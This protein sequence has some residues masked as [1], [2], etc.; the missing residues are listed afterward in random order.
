MKKATLR[1]YHF[2][3]EDTKKH[4]WYGRLKWNRKNDDDMCLTT[5]VYTRKS[6][7]YETTKKYAKLLNLEIVEFKNKELGEKED[8]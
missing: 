1:F 2:Y 3:S 7:V 8:I 6:S 4:S 5:R